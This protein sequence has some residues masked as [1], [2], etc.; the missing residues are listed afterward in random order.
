ME[1]RTRCITWPPL[2]HLKANPGNTFIRQSSSLA[3]TCGIP[4][5]VALPSQ[6]ER[7]FQGWGPGGSAASCLC[8]TVT[9][10]GEGPSPVL[11]H[12]LLGHLFLW[13]WWH[14]FSGFLWGLIRMCMCGP[15]YPPAKTY[16]LRQQIF[17]SY[18][19]KTQHVVV[20]GKWALGKHCLWA[21]VRVQ[22]QETDVPAQTT[23]DPVEASDRSPQKLFLQPFP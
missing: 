13:I 21:R 14:G 5:G 22:K 23:R 17:V 15:I 2:K 18:N 8:C 1:A 10:A 7:D 20:S 3:S 9:L 12:P 16:Y 4:E 11:G 19:W 6:W